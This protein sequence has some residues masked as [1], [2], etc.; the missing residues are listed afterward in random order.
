[1]SEEAKE[2]LREYFQDTALID[3]T[4]PVGKAFLE[5]RH[6]LNLMEY[7]DHRYMYKELPEHIVVRDITRA[8]EQ[9][10]GLV[11]LS[12]L[13]LV[14]CTVV[15]Y[16]LGR[17]VVRRALRDLDRL[18]DHVRQLD[19]YTLKSPLMLMHL[20]E[21]DEV[22]V[23]TDAVN[24]AHASLHEQI[25]RIKRFVSHASHELKTPLMILQTDSE[26]A[27]KTKTY[28]QGLQ[29]NLAT[30]AH[31]NRLLET[32]L[33]ISRYQSGDDVVRDNVLVSALVAKAIALVQQATTKPL[34]RVVELDEQVVVHAHAGIIE[35]IVTNVVENAI[36][37]TPAQ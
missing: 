24:Q 35:R 16:F 23:V 32:L 5:N 30:I 29:K 7:E 20:P 15:S 14:V 10:L 22:R 3:K 4:K 18:V 13:V 17:W 25:D 8:V 21:D 2:S 31:V 28:E 27:L 26:L 1:M 19:V 36:K 6:P 9:Q 34:H 11:R 37:Y 12:F 33:L